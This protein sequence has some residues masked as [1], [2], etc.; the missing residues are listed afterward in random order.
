MKIKPDENLPARLLPLPRLHGHDAHAV[1]AEQLTVRQDATGQAS[2]AL[3]PA[4]CL[5]P[6]G[7]SPIYDR[8]GLDD[9]IVSVCAFYEPDAAAS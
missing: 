7:H 4:S 6:R 1:F 5:K 2:D 8:E 9:G 3:T